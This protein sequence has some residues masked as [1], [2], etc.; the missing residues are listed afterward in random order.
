VA[1]HWILGIRPEEKG[2][3]VEPS[4]P[5][6]WKGFKVR[7]KFRGAIYEIEVENPAGV[8]SGV[9]SVTIDGQTLGDNLLPVFADGKTHLVKVVMG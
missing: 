8:N 5:K 1:S 6:H 2:L 4:I 7:R 3:L 9:R